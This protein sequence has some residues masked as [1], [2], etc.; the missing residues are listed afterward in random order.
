[1]LHQQQLHT[2]AIVIA[3]INYDLAKQST[4]A[5]RQDTLDV[6]AQ[7][8]ILDFD[9]PAALAYGKIRNQLER[10]GTPI[11]AMDMLIAAQAISAD[12]TLITNNTTEF[13]KVSNLQILDW[14]E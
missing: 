7:T 10:A 6:L 2:P 11:G 1:M 14:Q 4:Q 12:L 5:L 9:P 3:E 8:T 13:Q